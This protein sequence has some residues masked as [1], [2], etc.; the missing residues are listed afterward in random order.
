MGVARGLP[1]KPAL[2]KVVHHMG[3][4]EQLPIAVPDRID[5]HQR[6]VAPAVLAYPPTFALEASV[7]LSGLQGLFRQACLAILESVKAGIGMA[8]DF[9]ALVTEQSQQTLAPGGN[10]AIGVQGVQGVLLH[11]LVE[12]AF[13]M[14]QRNLRLPGFHWNVHL[15][16]GDKDR[17]KRKDFGGTP[18]Y[19]L[20]GVTQAN[21]ISKTFVAINVAIH[22][23]GNWSL[24]GGPE[25]NYRYGK[26]SRRCSATGSAAVCLASTWMNVRGDD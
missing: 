23:A 11:R 13:F 14:A 16:P 5:H 21:P 6:P 3:E 12:P 10:R 18:A 15:S 22:P 1:G 20:K 26:L 9:I 4:T 19:R 2:A 8:T 24:P 7:P 25:N 17:I